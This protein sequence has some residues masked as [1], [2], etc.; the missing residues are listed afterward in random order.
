MKKLKDPFM[1][2]FKLE[3]AEYNR[4]KAICYLEG[5]N[6]SRD[7]RNYVSSVVQAKTDLNR[8]AQQN[9]SLESPQ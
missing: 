1:W 7:M 2:A 5:T 3:R 4:Y 9:E 8:L 6:P